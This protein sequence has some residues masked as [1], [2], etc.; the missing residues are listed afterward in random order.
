MFHVFFYGE[1]YCLLVPCFRFQTRKSSHSKIKENLL[2]IQIHAFRIKIPGGG[3]EVQTNM[4]FTGMCCWTGYDFLPLFTKQGIQFRVRLS[5]GY[6]L[7]DWFDLLDEF[8]LYSKYTK[9]VTITWKEDGVHFVLCPKQ[10]NKIE[11]LITKQR[12][13]KRL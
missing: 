12:R 8:C 11:T 1:R 10:G 7:Y 3:G 4:A 5:T 6:C 2:I 9:A 13:E